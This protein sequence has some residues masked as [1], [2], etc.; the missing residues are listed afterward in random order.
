MACVMSGQSCILPSRILLPRSRYEEGIALL[1]T[2]MENFP[3]GDPWTP[4][5]MQGPQISETQRQKVLGLIRGGVAAGGRLITG[6]GI[7]ENLPTGYYVQPTLLADVDPNSQISQEEIFGPVLTVTPYDTDDDAI[8]IA[9]NSIYG[10][11]GEVSSGDVD[12]AMG[13]AK[14]MRTGNVTIN[15]KSHF[16][17][18]SPFGGTKQSGLGRRNGDEG[19]REYL[20]AKTIGL[21][22]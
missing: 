20:E 16:G 22:A 3:V 19:Y 5:I 11:S 2:S 17:I 12:R 1:K 7:P 13:V 8:A 15:G 4:G 14:R 18:T 21:P 10:L 6:G 9:N